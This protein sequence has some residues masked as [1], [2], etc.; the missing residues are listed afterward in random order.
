MKILQGHYSQGLPGYCCTTLCLED[1]RLSKLAM[2]LLIALAFCV[3]SVAADAF[4]SIRNT[5]NTY[6]L[7][8]DS[9]DFPALSS[10]FLPDAV[11]NYSA[12]LGILTGLP[13]IEHELAGDLAPVTTQHALSTSVIDVSTDGQ[14]ANTKT[15]F[16]ATHFGHGIY[17]GQIYTAYGRYEDLLIL[18]TDGW[19]IKSRHLV[20]MVCS[21]RALFCVVACCSLVVLC[22]DH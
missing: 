15:Y 5:L 18:G 17:N 2:R 20:Y 21:L 9:K 4:Q 8:I 12:P 14:S 11:A 10:V 7:A 22:R 6:P 16:T 19:R 1:Y 3:G 13:T